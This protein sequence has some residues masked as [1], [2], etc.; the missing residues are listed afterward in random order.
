MNIRVYE[1]NMGEEGVG[2][3]ITIAVV[4]QNTA[5]IQLSLQADRQG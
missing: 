1:A 3:D 2:S 5:I 4:N